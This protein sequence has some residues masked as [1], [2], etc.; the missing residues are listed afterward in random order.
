[1]KFV[2]PAVR[3][4]EGITGKIHET[5]E[6]KG[7]GKT[8]G[9][10]ENIVAD[11]KDKG[12]ERSMLPA[13]PQDRATED[14]DK[15]LKKNKPGGGKSRIYKQAVASTTRKKGERKRRREEKE[16]RLKKH[17]VTSLEM[18][19]NRPD[20]SRAVGSTDEK[21]RKN[22]TQPTPYRMKRRRLESNVIPSKGSGRKGRKFQ[23]VVKVVLLG[24]S[25]GMRDQ[26]KMAGKAGE[27]QQSKRWN[28][29]LNLAG[30]GTRKGMSQRD[31]Y[32]GLSSSTSR[33]LRTSGKR[34]RRQRGGEGEHHATGPKVIVSQES[35]FEQSGGGAGG[36]SKS[37]C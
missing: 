21:P 37:I 33:W 23:H 15:D 5:R 28:L 25:H 36:W 11:G 27:L 6:K 24:S 26:E 2:G 13:L 31:S 35:K 30:E 14:R 16:S 7:Y 9:N 20:K 32:C 19:G 1:M 22:R 4:K 34:E 10:V 29:L 8:E 18:G 12:G 3:G 17:T